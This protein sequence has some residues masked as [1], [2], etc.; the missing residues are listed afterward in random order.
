MYTKQLHT[1]A[2]HGRQTNRMMLREITSADIGVGWDRD[3]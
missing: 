1:I 3:Y 2:D